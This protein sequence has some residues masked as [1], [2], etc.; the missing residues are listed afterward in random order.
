MVLAY[1]YFACYFLFL[2]PG[3]KLIIYTLA[4]NHRM[5]LDD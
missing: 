4:L 1:L 2:K 5:C 3:D